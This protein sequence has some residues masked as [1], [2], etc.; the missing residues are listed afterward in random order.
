MLVLLILSKLVIKIS[1][2]KKKSH[3]DRIDYLFQF[4]GYWPMRQHHLPRPKPNPIIWHTTSA[5]I[6]KSRTRGMPKP[7]ISNKH[8]IHSTAH[9]GFCRPSTSSR[10]THPARMVERRRAPWHGARSRA[11][12]ARSTTNTLWKKNIRE[13]FSWTLNSVAHFHFGFTICKS[14]TF[15]IRVRRES[16][17]S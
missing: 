3:S 15:M 16:K 14:F 2:R 8:I 13:N 5:E 12:K 17:W 11:R 1:F 9:R 10:T 6:I 4:L 7:I